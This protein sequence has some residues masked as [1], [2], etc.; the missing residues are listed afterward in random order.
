[1][2]KVLNG[3]PVAQ[4]VFNRISAQTSA[5]EIPRM[6]LIKVGDDP[7]SEYYTQNICRQASKHRLSA[8]LIKLTADISENEL[9]KLILKLNNM[10]DIHGI[11][12]QKPL[13]L[14]ISESNINVLINPLK[15]I[16]GIHPEN[17]GRIFLSMDGF[18]PCTALSVLEI[19]KY[20][21]IDT[22]SKHVVIIGRSPIVAKPLAGLLLQ[23]DKLGNATVT[24]CHSYTRDIESVTAKADIL[25]SAIGVPNFVKPQHMKEGAICIDVGIN[26][27]NIN[28]EVSFVGDF[29]YNLCYS[30]AL[31]ITPVPGGVG[32]VT[33][34]LLLANLVKAYLMQAAKKIY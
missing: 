29:D 3:K 26:Q 28:D 32:S 11:M 18:C 15:D 34:S 21:K 8:E 2:D 19:I 9:S 6:A 1:M 13:P 25:V 17:L 24:V 30:K 5:T 31:A 16:D 20:Y 7:A 23:K 22:T 10:P 33:T 12:L 27:V 4:A 14:H